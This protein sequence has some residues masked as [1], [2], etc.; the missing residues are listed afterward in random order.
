MTSLAPVRWD[1][2]PFAKLTVNELYALLLLRQL[3]FCVEQKCAYLDC[4]GKDP[5]ALHLLGRAPAGRLLGYARLLPSHVSYAEPSIG[6]VVSHP[7]AR[8]TGLGKAVMREAIACA[9]DTYGST[10]IR[11]GA[12]LY[13]KRFYEDVGFAV[14]GPAYDEDGIPHVE[15]LRPAP[16]LG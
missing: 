15:M 14:S 1:L 9:R 11:I 16:E 4:D 2:I 5:K 12:Q 3:V 6:R 13:L 10:A 7:D 8:G